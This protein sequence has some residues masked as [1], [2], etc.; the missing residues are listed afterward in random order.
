[1]KFVVLFPGQGSQIIGM[2]KSI[3]NSSF[4]AK[5][6]FQEIDNT[7]NENLSKIMF[8]GP[9]NKLDLTINT[10]PAIM[11]VSIALLRTLKKE[12]NIDLTK[13]AKYFLGHSLGEISAHTASETLTLRD[14]AKITR[15]R[16]KIMQENQSIKKEIMAAIIGIKI[17]T[18]NKI[19]KSISNKYICSIANDN[20]HEEIIISG[21]IK[22]VNKIIK[23]SILAGAKKTFLLP[24]NN[25]FHSSLMIKSANNIKKKLKNI[26]F[27]KARV[28]IISNVTAKPHT[29]PK[30]LNEL[31]VKQT[32]SRVR[33]RESIEFIINKD[34]TTF[35]EIGSRSILS[36]FIK[37]TNPNLKTI[38]I[39]NSQDIE[40][41][42]SMF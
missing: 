42:I 7:L 39:N 33:W 9:K 6:V 41:I 12:A 21:Q 16:G 5:S 34:I 24:I 4:T 20:Y 22:A 26:N 2:G 40:K 18:L 25:A 15:Y 13:K 14:A 30:I 3:F 10:Q 11:A 23:L 36:N 29:Q 27:H 31:L 28:P 19:I 1:M 32:T 35:I 17:Q 37:Q 38:T 8:Y